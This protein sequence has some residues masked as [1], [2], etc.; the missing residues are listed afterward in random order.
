MCEK[1]YISLFQVD[2]NYYSF[3]HNTFFS[4][5]KSLGLKLILCDLL[6]GGFQGFSE[7]CPE[8]C[9]NSVSNNLSTVEPEPTVTGRTTPAY[10]QVR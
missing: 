9:Y 6:L 2:H 10:D 1:N 4:F 5:S 7:A 3:I 8:L